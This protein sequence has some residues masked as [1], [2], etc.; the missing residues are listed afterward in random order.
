MNAIKISE[1]VLMDGA[2]LSHAIKSKQVS[3]IEVMTVYLDHIGIFNPGVVLSSRCSHVT[4]CWSKP[5]NAT[6][7]SHAGNI[8]AG[9]T[10]FPTR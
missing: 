10:A 4:C 7:S 2:A 5:T 3:C 1:I 6:H 9:C 8:S